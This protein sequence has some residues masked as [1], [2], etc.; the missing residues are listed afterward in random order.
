LGN[1]LN[2]LNLNSIQSEQIIGGQPSISEA[3]QSIHN[4]HQNILEVQLSAES[5]TNTLKV[6]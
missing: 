6:I 3:Q 1:F 4:A 2:D 5:N